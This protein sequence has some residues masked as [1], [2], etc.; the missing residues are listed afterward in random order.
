MSFSIN[1]I[2]F[3]FLK[4]FDFVP[5]LLIFGHLHRRR[6]VT[7]TPEDIC[8]VFAMIMNCVPDTS[9]YVSFCETKQQIFH[10]VPWVWQI[11]SGIYWCSS[12]RKTPLTSHPPRLQ[13]AWEKSHRVASTSTNTEEASLWETNRREAG[14]SNGQCSV[15]R[16]APAGC[17]ALLAL[18]VPVN[19]VIGLLR[20]NDAERVNCCIR[21]C[22]MRVLAGAPSKATFWTLTQL[23]ELTHARYTAKGKTKVSQHSFQNIKFH[24]RPWLSLKRGKK[25]LSSQLLNIY[26]I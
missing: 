2:S 13:R 15:S 19:D 11:S 7:V 12:L 21:G 20:A 6:Q 22:E 10:V 4:A 1:Q 18:A 23:Q 25:T 8:L 9:F 3:W 17:P 16:R 26:W 5:V 24:Q 14:D